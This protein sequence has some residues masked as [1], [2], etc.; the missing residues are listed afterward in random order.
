MNQPRWI[1]VA[2]LLLGM[3]PAAA[4]G[5]GWKMPNLNPFARN[6]SHPA[7]VRMADDENA[8]WWKPKF[9]SV[10]ASRT[11]KSSQP[12]TWTKISR[13]TRSAWSKTTDALN[14]FNDAND[15]PKPITGYNTAF[16][17]PSR[18][19]EEKSSWWPSWGAEEPKRPQT[20]QD[21]I[22]QPRPY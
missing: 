15:K 20:V 12:S 11:R 22:G 1:A 6:D 9:P 7:N 4:V 14:P 16:S 8:P 5:Q 13:G 3:L 2:V 21:F 17:R 10:T 18:R 19:T